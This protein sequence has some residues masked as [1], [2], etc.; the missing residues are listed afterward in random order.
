MVV[1]AALLLTRVSGATL[2]GVELV[3]VTPTPAVVTLAEGTLA[4]GTLLAWPPVDAVLFVSGVIVA[5]AGCTGVD[6]GF[7]AVA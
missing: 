2:A 5:A 4:E 7:V 1:C 6:T 3:G